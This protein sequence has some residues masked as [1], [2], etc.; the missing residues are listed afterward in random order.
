MSNTFP[1]DPAINAAS[2]TPSDSAAL[3][4]NSRGLYVGGTGDLKVDMEGTGTVTFYGVAAGSILPIR[5]KRVYSTGT[6]ATYILS[7][8]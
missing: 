1:S 4:H 3:S 6:T 5:A 8:S 2:V 7:L